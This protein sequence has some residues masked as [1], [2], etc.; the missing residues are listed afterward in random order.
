MKALAFAIILSLA[1]FS[2]GENKE[3]VSEDSAKKCAMPSTVNPNGDSELALLMRE[4]ADWTDSCKAAITS[5]R[6]VPAAPASLNSLHT[7]KRTDPNIDEKVFSSMASLYQSRVTEFQASTDMNRVELFNSMV[8]GCVSCH[9]NFCHGP[10]VRINKM[11]IPV[12]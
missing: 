12:N 10:L 3:T 2:C 1:M 9:E 5:K 8:Q 7:A 4:M 6:E 11:L